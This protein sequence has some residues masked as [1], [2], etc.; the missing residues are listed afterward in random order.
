M[1]IEVKYSN[2]DIPASASVEQVKKQSIEALQTLR[3]GNGLG[4][5]FLGWVNLP[6]EITE[7]EISRIEAVAQRVRKILKYLLWQVLAVLILEQ[8]W[9]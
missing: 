6:A 9:S 1:K 8:E 5:D 2:K 3:N 7:E 4:N